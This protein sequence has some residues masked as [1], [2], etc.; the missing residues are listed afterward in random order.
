MKKSCKNWRNHVAIA[1]NVL[2]VKK[3]KIYP[4]YISKNNSNRQKK[5]ILLMIPNGERGKDKSVALSSSKRISALLKGI[6]SKNNS[7]FYCPN[8]P[9]AFKTKNILEL[10]K[11]VGENK[12][13]CKVVMSSEDTKTFEFN[14]Y[15][16]SDKTP[17]IFYAD[18]EYI[19]QKN[20]GCKNVTEN[21]SATSVSQNIPPGFSISTIFSFRGIENKHNVYRDED[22]MKM[23]SEFLR[24]PAVKMIN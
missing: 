23:F 22:C 18:L 2:H 15:Q 3:V 4:A 6:T 21:S 17:F 5:V 9:H 12:G 7:D 13:F 24:K 1:L 8:C 14:Q 20:D 16:K 10:N 19:I 11:K